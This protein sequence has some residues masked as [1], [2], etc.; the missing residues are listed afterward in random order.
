MHFKVAL[1]SLKAPS[2][3]SGDELEAFAFFALQNYVAMHNEFS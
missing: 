1:S 2:S 3:A